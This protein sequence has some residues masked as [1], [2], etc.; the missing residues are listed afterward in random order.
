LRAT[1]E[2]E[3]R[4]MQAAL[5]RVV[6]I[7]GCVAVGMQ[8]VPTGRGTIR[9][10]ASRAHQTEM[11]NPKVG[12][13]LDRSCQDCHSDQTHVPWYGRVAPVSWI[14][15]RDVRK[16]RAKLDFSQ[17]A[18]RPHSTNERM[19]ICDAVSDGSMPLRAY[20]VLH[21]DARLSK[22]DVAL[23]CDWAASPTSN[24][25]PVQA[26]SSNRAQTLTSSNYARHLKLKGS[27]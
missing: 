14:L 5:K 15:S 19:E 20:T 12:A 18:A 11:I 8:L 22:E 1:L 24:E 10:A 27:R 9:I 3:K 16:G 7:F 6:T 13:I 26:E 17:W 4:S 25:H 21:R 23:I 2:R